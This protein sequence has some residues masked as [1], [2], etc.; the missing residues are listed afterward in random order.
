MWR[1][2][3]SH[4]LLITAI[5][6]AWSAEP[7]GPLPSRAKPDDAEQS[8]AFAETV[9]DLNETVLWKPATASDNPVTKFGDEVRAVFGPIPQ[10]DCGDGAAQS[11]SLQVDGNTVDLKPNLEKPG[12]PL[13]FEHRNAAGE[14]VKWTTGIAQCDRPSLAGDVTYCG[15]NS[16]VSRVVKGNIEWLTFCR[17]SMAH[18]RIEPVPYWEKSNPQYSRLGMIGFNWATGEI[19]FFDGRHDGALFDWTKPSV[20]PG[21]QSYGDTLG[22]AEAEAIY[23][24]T[25]QVQCSACHDN[26]GPYVL[27]PH[28]RQLQ[29]GRHL[30][31][32]SETLLTDLDDYLPGSSNRDKAPFRV[33]GSTY[34]K[35]YKTELQNAKTVRD[36]SGNCTEC[37]S[38][39][40]QLTGQR[41]APDAVAKEPWVSDP[42]W[43]QILRVRAEQTKLLQI[44]LHRTDWARRFGTGRIHPWMVPIYGT[45]VSQGTRGISD[46]D[47]HRL[48]NCL[49]DAGG[50]ECGYQP[51][52][53]PCPPPGTGPGG[54]GSVV[55]NVSA[56]K[57]SSPFGDIAASR[58]RLTWMYR[59]SYG[60][61][62]ERDDVRFDAA[63]RLST[64]PDT[65]TPRE[66]DYPTVEDVK[67][68]EIVDHGK[69]VVNA[70]DFIRV[71]DIAYSGHRKYTE[72]EASSEPRT[73]E[74]VLPAKCNRR[75]LVLILPKRFCFDQT[76][77]VYADR[78]ER[79][80]ADIPCR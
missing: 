46:N 20:P 77:V 43:S 2:V 3:K 79:L 74:L 1:N 71:H 56:T 15:M 42:D 12:R 65:A 62:S 37:H 72:A 70:R 59:N 18:Q 57:A 39:T 29:L 36:P 23:D 60:D 48:S 30:K 10:G 78:G 51:L 33:V 54:D 11:L 67:D 27:T 8:R 9:R 68:E 31:S 53:T 38:L 52:Y 5:S 40:T 80:Y 66:G 69:A 25:F 49:W 50:E 41:F 19:A 44:D 55:R 32:R 28:I 14:F 34:T 58:L 21:G 76:G 6:L 4:A 35:I 13:E 24:P 45:D 16:R 47:W 73:Y 75:Y 17:K 7:M 22:R 63:I 26:K 64:L 61:V